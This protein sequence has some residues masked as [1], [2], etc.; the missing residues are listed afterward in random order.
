MAASLSH[1]ESSRLRA[2]SAQFL[3]LP[4]EH[5]AEIIVAAVERRRSRVIVG[6]DAWLLSTLER[7]LPGEYGRVLKRLGLDA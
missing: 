1:E 4:P 7:L 3:R 2:R 5:A 6:R